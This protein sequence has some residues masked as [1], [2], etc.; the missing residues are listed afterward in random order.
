MRCSRRRHTLEPSVR[1]VYDQLF[2]IVSGRLRPVESN[3]LCVC[4]PPHGLRRTQH[5]ERIYSGTGIMIRPRPASP[6]VPAPGTDQRQ[7]LP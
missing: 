3:T 1:I 6:A 5:L 2:S 4:R 7:T